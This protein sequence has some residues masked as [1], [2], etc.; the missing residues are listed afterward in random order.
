MKINIINKI[1]NTEN[2]I[3]RKMRGIL[4][5]PKVKKR[6][7]FYNGMLTHLMDS[8]GE[9]PKMFKLF[10]EIARKYP[11]Y[12]N[13]DLCSCE[14]D[15]YRHPHIIL[16]HPSMSK[17]LD[18][19]VDKYLTV[20]VSV[21]SVFIDKDTFFNTSNASDYDFYADIC[22]NCYIYGDEPASRIDIERRIL[23]WI[24]PKNKHKVIIAR[25]TANLLYTI[26]ALKDNNID[27]HISIVSSDGDL[28]LKTYE[29][30]ED[31][32]MRAIRMRDTT[33]YEHAQI[34]KDIR[35]RIRI[36]NAELEAV[37]RKIQSSTCRTPS[38]IKITDEDLNT[39]PIL[40]HADLCNHAVNHF[41]IYGSEREK[42]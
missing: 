38:F 1:N 15:E 7:V 22:R 12:G 26:S 20:D 11:P 10:K 28:N 2:D 9:I 8:T 32:I 31:K 24:D 14:V 33:E 16:L 19:I 21:G 34:Y 13:V 42:R 35:D 6:A 5:S 36:A 40:Y 23:K 4:N 27:I 37:F 29:L 3:R 30:Y 41:A 17:N 18:N 25:A 39:H